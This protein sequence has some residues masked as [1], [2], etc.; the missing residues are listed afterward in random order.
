MKRIARR[1]AAVALS[2]TVASWTLFVSLP[3]FAGSA[4]A[5]GTDYVVSADAGETYTPGAAIGN[6]A[7]LVKRGAGEVVLTVP[8]TEFAGPVLVEEGTLSITSLFALGTSSPV[9]VASGATFYLK[10]PHGARQDSALFSAHAL[11]IAGD[12]VDG[13]GAIRYLPS[14]GGAADDSLLGVI[15]LADDATIECDYRWGVH[16]KNN[17]AVNLNGHRLRRIHNNTTGS[18]WMLNGATVDGTGTVEAYKGTITFQG[19]VTSSANATYVATNSG[20]LTIYQTTKD[21]PSAL[22]FFPEQT[23]TVAAGA[24]EDHNR[25]SGP[26][27]LANHAGS[28][29]DGRVTF[30]FSANSPAAAVLHLD[31]PIA[32]D[33]GMSFSV[34]RKASGDGILFLNGDVSIGGPWVY[35]NGG[36]FLAMT[37]GATRAFATGIGVNG[38]SRMLVGGGHTRIDQ[39]GVGTD[40]TKGKGSFRQTGGVFVVTN[41]AVVG[42]SAL[43][44]TLRF[45]P[46]SIAR[47]LSICL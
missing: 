21:I 25:F 23:F 18:P 14:D 40:P 30:A 24:N 47:R 11:T 15:D 6:Y 12:G 3:A 34:S 45:V 31:G 37:S 46:W 2:A 33:A 22:T 43:N 38:G 39:I 16:G 4:G 8:S 7:R 20:S 35:V 29:A 44:G 5:D 9:T 36:T 13:R 17:G 42:G 27:R 1:N 41:N 32:G 26:I 19:G 10:T 28:A